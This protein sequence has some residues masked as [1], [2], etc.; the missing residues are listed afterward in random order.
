MHHGPIEPEMGLRSR[1][2]RRVLGT[3]GAGVVGGLAGCGSL[4]DRAGTTTPSGAVGSGQ[5]Q[6]ET[7]PTTNLS[8]YRVAIDGGIALV[9]QPRNSEEATPGRVTVFEWTGDEWR[10]QAVLTSGS[11]RRDAFGTSVA[12]DGSTALVGAPSDRNQ[13]GEPTGSAYVFERSGGEW[14]RERRLLPAEAE[15]DDGVG[16]SVAIHGGTSLVGAS[17]HVDSRADRVAGAAY[18]FGRTERQWQRE[19][20]LIAEDEYAVVELGADVALS[21]ET[22]LVGAPQAQPVSLEGRSVSKPDPGGPPDVPWTAGATYVFRRGSRGWSQEAKLLADPPWPSAFG[23]AVAI[24]G[25]RAAV[26]NLRQSSPEHRQTV[27]VFERRRDGWTLT[28]VPSAEG[29]ESVRFGWSVA[30]DGPWLIVGTPDEE[31]PTSG[32]TPTSVPR[33]ESERLRRRS[34]EDRGAV[35]VFRQTDGGWTQATKLRDLDESG[36]EFF[37]GGSVAL[38]GSTALIGTGNAAYVERLADGSDPEN[39][40]DP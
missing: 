4:G 13:A 18:V 14:T 30:L 35:T 15:A 3:I 6:P 10:R 17:G 22:A 11:D 19:A 36:A 23:E 20:K 28:T 29:R 2:R 37:V 21:G 34:I 1:S 40:R 9:G 32:P 7:D 38:D 8:G 5:L 31:V 33:N 27:S 39:R 24:D 25:D 16:G 12:L 26:T